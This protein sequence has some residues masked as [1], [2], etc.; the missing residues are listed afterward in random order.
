M[1]LF[2]I[3][4][5]EAEPVTLTEA[6]AH[7]AIDSTDFDTLLTGY[8]AAVRAHVEKT[9]G[10]TLV[11]QTW[12]LRLPGFPCGAIELPRP[13]LQSVTSVKYT[14]EAGAVQ[15]LSPSAYQVSGIDGDQPASVAPAFGMRWPGARHTPEAVIVRFVCGY[16]DDGAS[17]PNPAANVPPQIRQAIIEMIADLFANRETTGTDQAYAIPIPTT[18]RALLQPFKVWSLP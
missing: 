2:L 17:P 10:R 7:C 18:A 9:T 4:A 11:S 6:K 5:P 14:D 13:P 15:T 16:P 3:E 8:I 1:S 12:E